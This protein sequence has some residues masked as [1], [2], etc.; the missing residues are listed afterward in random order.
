MQINAEKIQERETTPKPGAFDDKALRNLNRTSGGKKGLLARIWAWLLLALGVKL[1]VFGVDPENE[2]QEV[3]DGDGPRGWLFT[4]VDVSQGLE[5][6]KPLS[7]VLVPYAAGQHTRI[8][9]VARMA[10]LHA[11][12]WQKYRLVEEGP[13]G[14]R[15]IARR[16]RRAAVSI[17]RRALNRDS[18]THRRCERPVA[19]TT[20]V[21]AHYGKEQGIRDPEW[22]TVD[23][24]RIRPGDPPHMFRE[25]QDLL[26]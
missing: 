14:P 19:R 18:S 15:I 17:M 2:A 13:L 7:R 1:D 20:D 24:E 6:G 3:Q 21:T 26:G 9:Y 5:K 16:E 22:E 8:E 12:K 11:G 10:E 25:A 23:L 4:L